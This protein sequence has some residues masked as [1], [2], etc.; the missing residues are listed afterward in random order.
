MLSIKVYMYFSKKNSS[1]QLI[2]YFYFEDFLIGWSWSK[3]IRMFQNYKNKLQKW[4]NLWFEQRLLWHWFDE[5]FI[6]NQ[7]IGIANH[8]SEKSDEE[9]KIYHTYYQWIPFVLFCYGTISY[10]PRFFWKKVFEKERMKKLCEGF[11]SHVSYIN[12]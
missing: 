6:C 1:N 3:P 10:I 8:N 4:Q 5:F 12:Y 11:M 9:D 7:G 2:R